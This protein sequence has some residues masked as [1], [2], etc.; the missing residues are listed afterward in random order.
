VFHDGRDDALHVGV[1]GL[2]RADH[3]EEVAVEA[4]D[5]HTQHIMLQ[6]YLVYYVKNGII[7]RL[8]D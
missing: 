5:T 4:H 8:S 1:P 3:G 7:G 6:I 2:L